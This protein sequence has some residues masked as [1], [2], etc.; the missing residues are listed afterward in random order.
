MVDD[1]SFQG[2]V[3]HQV[4][5]LLSSNKATSLEYIWKI[6]ENSLSL[7]IKTKDYESIVSVLEKM[8]DPS[9]H[10]GKKEYFIKRCQEIIHLN[11]QAQLEH[12]NIPFYN[13]LRNYSMNRAKKKKLIRSSKRV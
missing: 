5:N 1:Q 13:F 8:R 11:Q 9:G 2:E 10:L 4:G 7:K 12:L 3:F 6:L